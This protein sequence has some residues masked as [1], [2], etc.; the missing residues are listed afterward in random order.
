MQAAVT[1]RQ[2][3]HVIVSAPCITFV[4]VPAQLAVPWGDPQWLVIT[5]DSH[6]L[7]SK[8]RQG[9]TDSYAAARRDALNLN[10]L[11][12]IFAGSTGAAFLAPLQ[13]FTPPPDPCCVCRPVGCWHSRK[14]PVPPTHS[15]LTTERLALANRRCLR[16]GGRSLTLRPARLS[17]PSSV[18]PNYL[19]ATR[20]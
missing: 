8:P 5:L 3:N 10:V 20:Q 9:A 16:V 1:Q 14:P 17:G 6:A 15:Y 2:N 4:P 19:I 18:S 7:N 11:G 13:K 12:N